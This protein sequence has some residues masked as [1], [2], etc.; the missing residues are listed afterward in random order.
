MAPA[1]A[2]AAKAELARQFAHAVVWY[3][4]S[5]R[6]WWAMVWCGRVA[7]AS[8]SRSTCPHDERYLG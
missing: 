1:Q 4:D 7:P 3:G 6:N 2:I 5:T 8:S